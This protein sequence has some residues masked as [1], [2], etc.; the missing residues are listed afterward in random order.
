VGQQFVSVSKPKQVA[1]GPASSELIPTDSGK[2]GILD[3]VPGLSRDSVPIGAVRS[4][5]VEKLH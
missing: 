2:S 1:L 3:I 4:A 5:V